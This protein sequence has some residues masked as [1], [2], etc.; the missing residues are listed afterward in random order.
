[1][2]S[3]KL[4]LGNVYAH[5]CP[6]RGILDTLT[7]RWGV[8]VQIALLEKTYRFRELSRKVGGVSEKMLA[9]TLQQ[10]EEDGFVHRKAYPEIPPRVEYSLTPLGRE[11]A[12]QLKK[13]V[14]WIEENVARVQKAKKVA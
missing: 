13:F 7:S 12:T 14:V 1:M 6:T 10:L 5:D 4:P 11:A 2:A 9:Q 8:L 3:R